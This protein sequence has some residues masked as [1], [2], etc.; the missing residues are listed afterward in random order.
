MVASGP[1]RLKVI[2]KRKA[3]ATLLAVWP[4]VCLVGCETLSP[5]R[6]PLSASLHTDSA[7]IGVRHSGFAYVAK[8]GFLYTNTTAK[9]V[10]KAGC[11]GPPFPDL[12]KKVN[13]Q[14][15]GAYYPAYLMCLTKP[16]FMLESGQKYHGVLEF[17]AFERGHNTMPELRVDSNDGIYRLRWD[18][19]E[20]IDATAKGARRVESTSNEFRMV[21]SE[22]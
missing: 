9:P 7:E 10:S 12:E 13:D 6:R 17:T 11:G 16:D 8:I 20:G 3:L 21:L 1:T 2:T 15:V 14:W 4:L 5:F 22:Q 18:F 19:V